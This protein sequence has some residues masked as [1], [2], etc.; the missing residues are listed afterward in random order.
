MRVLLALLLVC[1]AAGALAQ[2]TNAERS[3]SALEALS[4]MDRLDREARAA[5]GLQ[6]TEPEKVIQAVTDAIGRRDCPGAVS[7][8]NGGLAKAYPEVFNLAGVL[9]EEGICVKQ[10]W[11][12]AVT[13][14]QRALGAGHAGAAARLAAGYAS[15]V[16]G[17]DK[18]ASLWWAL[19]AKTA[20][21]EACK[22][23]AGLVDDPDRF[24]AA[25]QA[26]PAGRMDACAYSGAVMASV[27]A[28]AEAGST[29]VATSY[30][31]A[32]AVRVAFVPATSQVDFIDE[33][34]ATSLPAGVAVG[35]V[36]LEAGRRD[37]RRI[38]IAALRQR[39][40]LALKRYDKPATL[41]AEWRAEGSYAFTP[42]H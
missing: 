29:G 14:Y 21:P 32:G 30:G 17:R 20:L 24:V 8:L 9:Y 26:W 6:L 38:F 12:R 42:R 33:L 27:Q 7:A 18:A 36:D 39:A 1:A 23:V 5:R 3:K 25:L 37:A 15:P 16:G 35:N 13:L 40:E 11:E 31:L 4:D 22:Q 41:P 34:V 2:S 10:N 28:E 19:R